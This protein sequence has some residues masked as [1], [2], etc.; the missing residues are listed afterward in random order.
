VNRAV[1]EKERRARG[2]SSRSEVARLPQ[3]SAAS[4]KDSRDSRKVARREYQKK[5]HR[6]VRDNFDVAASLCRGVPRRVHSHGGTASWLQQ[7]KD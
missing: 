3:G 2:L 5:R 7:N 1:R 4:P 6:Q